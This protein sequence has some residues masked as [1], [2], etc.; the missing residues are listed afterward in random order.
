M[1][2]DTIELMDGSRTH[3]GLA[4]YL[5]GLRPVEMSFNAKNELL[6]RTYLDEWTDINASEAHGPMYGACGGRNKVF[7][8]YLGFYRSYLAAEFHIQM[9]QAAAARPLL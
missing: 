1:V 7:H 2:G 9:V 6:V 5:L 8:N 4:F 3:A